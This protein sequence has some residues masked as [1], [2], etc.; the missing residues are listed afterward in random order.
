MRRCI[1]PACELR[2]RY[3]DERRT[4]LVLLVAA[5]LGAAATIATFAICGL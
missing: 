1:C 3:T 5:C 2:Q 4:R